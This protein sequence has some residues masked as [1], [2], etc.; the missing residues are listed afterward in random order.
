MPDEC[1]GIQR[2]VILLNL[3]VISPLKMN[4]I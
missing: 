4:S 1:V 2:Y 3:L